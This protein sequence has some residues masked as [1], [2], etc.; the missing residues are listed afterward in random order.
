MGGG[1]GG[2]LNMELREFLPT[3]TYH[4]K[5]LCPAP[6]KRTPLLKESRFAPGHARWPLWLRA[7]A[8]SMCF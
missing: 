8:P 2:G 5:H 7:R 6:P 4:P 3:L 1:G